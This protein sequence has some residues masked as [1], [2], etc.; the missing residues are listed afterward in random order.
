M[1][2]SV[3]L[4]I[5][6]L[7]NAVIAGSAWGHLWSGQRRVEREVFS[8][9]RALGMDNGSPG[10]FLRTKEFEISQESASARMDRIEYEL[11]ALRNRTS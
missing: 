10:V 3:E 8:V 11:T 2:V 1:N 7:S 6:L 4:I 9:R 5:I